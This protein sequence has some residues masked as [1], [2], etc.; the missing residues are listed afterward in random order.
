MAQGFFKHIPNIIYDFKS[1]GEFYLAKDLFRNFSVWSYLQEGIT[2]YNYYR[3]IDGERPDVTAAKLYGDSTLYW[4]FFLVNENLQDFS[5]WPKSQ[6]LFERFMDRK[7]SGTCLVAPSSTDIVDTTEKFTLGEKVSEG[8]SETIAS[9]VTG[10]RTLELAN[11]NSFIKVG[12]VVTGG[13]NAGNLPLVQPTGI[14]GYVTVSAISGTTLVLSSDQTLV[15]STATSPL[16]FSS[17]VNYGFVTDINPTHNRIIVNDVQGY[18]TEGSSAVGANSGKEFIISSIQNEE[19]AVH[20][21]LD[22]NNQKT[23]V[24]SYTSDAS[25][26]PFEGGDTAANEGTGYYN[27]STTNNT[28]VT[29]LDYERDLN[30]DRHLIRYIEPRYIGTIVK[31]FKELIGD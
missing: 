10:G 2:G 4:T 17:L 28:L 20:H 30:E 7:Y 31:E 16:S 5:D 19:D 9:S 8:T 21:Y 6:I 11:T 22:S 25:N 27:Y 24:E 18:F 3:I 1:D 23:T 15:E 29:N 13:N 26:T 12:M 14:S